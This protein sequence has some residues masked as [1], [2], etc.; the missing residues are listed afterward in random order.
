MSSNSE[1]PWGFRR[2]YTVLGPMMCQVLAL[3][4]SG[5]PFMVVKR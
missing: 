4:V 1:H 3:V 5:E 2:T